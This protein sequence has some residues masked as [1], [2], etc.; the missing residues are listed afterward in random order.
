MGRWFAALALLVGAV[1]TAPAQARARIGARLEL[2]SD[3]PPNLVVHVSDLLNDPRWSDALTNAY[4][5]HLHWTV[6]LWQSRLIDRPLAPVEWDDIVQEVPVIDVYTF[7]ERTANS[8]TTETFHTA[9]S[10]ATWVGR[11]AR[12][13][14]PAALAPGRW[15]Y[16]VGLSIAA[17]PPGDARNG[18]DPP[19]AVSQLVRRVIMGSGNR[20]DLPQARTATFTVKGP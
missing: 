10:L 12:L 7:E 19:S 4:P 1:S 5:L 9:D 2:R 3:G 16:T 15:Y 13:V 20:E 14:T 18:D 8:T 17:D 6:V 11:E